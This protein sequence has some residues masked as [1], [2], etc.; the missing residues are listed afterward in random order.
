M[1]HVGVDTT[2]ALMID[3]CRRGP[4]GR[5]MGAG[6]VQ[7]PESHRVNAVPNNQAIITV[8]QQVHHERLFEGERGMLFG[9]SCR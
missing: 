8:E 6:R 7:R 3:T 1:H 5:L 2:G 9:A 4:T